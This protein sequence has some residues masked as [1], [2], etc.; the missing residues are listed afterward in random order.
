M[1][2]KNDTYYLDLATIEAVKKEAKKRDR[3]KSFIANE[4]LSKQLKVKKGK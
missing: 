3:S 2:S 1:A 4:A